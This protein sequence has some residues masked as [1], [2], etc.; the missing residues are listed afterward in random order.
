[1]ILNYQFKIG[2]N[3]LE[4]E[5]TYDLSRIRN[6]SA[7]AER[8][9]RNL[10]ENGKT[11]H[12]K[13]YL[14]FK[15]QIT[16]NL[17]LA[18]FNDQISKLK[19]AMSDPKQLDD[20]LYLASKVIEL[21]GQMAAEQ[22]YV[23][24][25]ALND[26]QNLQKLIDEYYSKNLKSIDMLF[27]G[28]NNN[29]NN[30][31]VFKGDHP[32]NLLSLM[33][34]YYTTC[35]L[36]QYELLLMEIFKKKIPESNFS[37]NNVKATIDYL[38]NATVNR[39]YKVMKIS[40]IRSIHQFLQQNKIFKKEKKLATEAITTDEAR[41]M[42]I[43]MCLFGLQPIIEKKS[44]PKEIRRPKLRDSDRES[45]NDPIINRIKKIFNDIVVVNKHLIADYKLSD[46]TGSEILE[47]LTN[48]ILK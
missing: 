36:Y 13:T 2:D 44:E 23:Y 46:N 47:L 43:I 16:S 22:Q 30:K 12:E 11:L 4:Q 27:T 42:Y 29:L 1:M 34:E 10:E 26:F 8:E 31:I 19:L 48:T 39:P 45:Y 28:N 33:I 9:A 17:E 20:I 24:Q 25:I 21:E 5:I 38:K 40:L 3:I 14:K 32:K 18:N 15:F 6:H 35:L 41:V 7:L 37:Y